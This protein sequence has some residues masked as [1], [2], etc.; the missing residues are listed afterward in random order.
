MGFIFSKPRA[1]PISSSSFDED[2]YV[3]HHCQAMPISSSKESLNIPPHPSMSLTKPPA[4]SQIGPFLGKPLCDITSIYSL[5]KELGR[6]QFGITYLC[7][8]KST[9]LKYTCK[10][11][12]MQKLQSEKSIEDIKR[13][14]LI[15]EHLAGQPNIREFKGAYEDKQ[16]LH[17]VNEL[18]YGGELFDHQI[19][20]KGSYLERGAANICRQIVNAVHVCHFMGVMHRNLKPENFLMVS[21][22]ENS[23]LKATG[24]GHSV[25]IDEAEG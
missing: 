1:T 17:L 25:F 22:D 19:I 16:N 9:G 10:S 4:S 12:S 14:I 15:L 11:I 5:D 3:P 7:T 23:E 8:E 2:D 13:E 24:F 18:C 20:A 6:D 21:Q